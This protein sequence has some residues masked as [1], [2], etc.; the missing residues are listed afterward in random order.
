MS[1]AISRIKARVTAYPAV[2]GTFL[3]DAIAP[4]ASEVDL[5]TDSY[6]PAAL[7]AVM[8]DT[9]LE[10][11]LDRVAGA[12]GMTRQPA[13]TATGKVTF[14]GTALTVIPAGTLVSTESGRVYATDIETT[15]PD[16]N[17]TIIADVTAVESGAAYNMPAAS[18]TVLPLALVGVTAVTNAEAISGGADIESDA[19]LRERLL[20]RIRLP[21]ASGCPADYVRWAREV[22]GI[23]AAACVPLWDGA[24]TVKVIVAGSGMTPAGAEI[25]TDVEEYIESVRPIGATVTV[26]S[27]TPLAVNVVATLVLES[28]YTVEGVQAA[29]E[30]ALEAVIAASEFG[31]T[32][33]PI[34]HIGAALL[35]VPGITDYSGLTLNAAAAN[36]SLTSEEVPELGTV[37]L[38]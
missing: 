33:L 13:T 17:T 22:P 5:F 29:V 26:V 12:Y 25:I 6:L 23:A 3:H 1:D 16:G 27:V 34:S 14:T 35:T 28:G 20:M 7:D 30:V 32:S 21:S 9:A 19:S 2:E 10:E 37:T 18:L 36:V 11:D 4:V 31:A 38:S 8:P 15:I 24:G